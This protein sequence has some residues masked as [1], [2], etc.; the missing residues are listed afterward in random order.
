MPRSLRILRSVAGIAGGKV[1]VAPL[2]VMVALRSGR[3]V[4]TTLA[5]S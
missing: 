5:L 3:N 2:M 4:L 1:W